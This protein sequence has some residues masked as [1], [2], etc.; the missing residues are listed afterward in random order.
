MT[1]LQPDPQQPSSRPPLGPLSWRDHVD[2]LLHGSRS[3]G[4]VAAAALL[5]VGVSVAAFAL[6]RPAAASPP[7]PELSLP[8]ASSSGP[9]ASSAT[10]SGVLVVHAA[11][12]VVHPGIYRVAGGS[13]VD[14]LLAAAGGLAP[15]AD[16]DRINLAAPL[17]DGERV[18]VPRVGQAVP[19][20]AGG[21]AS[22]SSRAGP[23][24]LNTATAADLDALPG[25]GPATAQAIV[26]ER[27]RRGGRFT[28]V[29]DLLDV[30]G[31]GP[32][33]LDELRPL[34]TVG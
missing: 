8:M 13:R 24:D 7:P 18:Y 22:T 32:A 12:A 10:P 27:T 17:T 33:K 25:V 1:D 3:P 5:I 9:A 19:A 11:G 31:I 29:D 2:E 16:A 21:D 14:D 28:S 26:A 30:R 34:V 6:L 20:D 15:D 4:R 23:V